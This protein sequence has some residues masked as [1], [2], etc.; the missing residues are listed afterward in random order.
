MQIILT[1]W[2]QFDPPVKPGFCCLLFSLP[3]CMSKT[4]L[5]RQR[6]RP[7]TMKQLLKRRTS[8]LRTILRC[9][10]HGAGQ[11]GNVVVE[12]TWNIVSN[13]V[14]RKRLWKSSFRCGTCGHGV[15]CHWLP[16]VDCR[17]QCWW[18]CC[19]RTSKA[20]DVFVYKIWE[21]TGLLRFSPTP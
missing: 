5:L 19:R 18:R 17:C 2:L 20:T 12:A 16:K 6:R 3:G 9:P 11:C 14:A 8:T 10:H 4:I 21:D 7:L 1:N 15:D 13:W